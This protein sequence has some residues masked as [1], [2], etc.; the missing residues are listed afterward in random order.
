MTSVGVCVV[1]MCN[2]CT[3][4]GS[5]LYTWVSGFGSRVSSNLQKVGNDGVA[6]F[7]CSTY[8]N[9]SHGAGEGSQEQL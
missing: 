3:S 2:V 9:G 7:M 4:V 6:G 5:W 1:T 8:C